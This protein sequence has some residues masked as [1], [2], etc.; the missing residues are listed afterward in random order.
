VVVTAATKRN[1]PPRLRV[2]LASEA[3]IGV[4]FRRGPSKLVRV[5]A[6]DRKRDKFRAC[7]RFNGRIL[8]GADMS[9]DGRYMMYSA[10]GGAAWAIPA[11]GGTWTAISRVPSLTAVALWGQSG[12][13]RG[14]RGMF[15][16]NHSY[17]LD[18]DANTFLIRDTN[19]LRREQK[20]RGCSREERDGWITTGPNVMNPAFEKTIPKGWTLRRKRRYP[21]H[22]LYEIE[23]PED[24]L[25]LQVPTWEWAD[26]DRDRLVWVEGGC[27]RAAKL[28]VRKLGTVRTLYDFNEPICKDS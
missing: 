4:V 14:C 17:C 16:S 25:T 24:G 21:K 1:A 27:L 19:M 18:S 3:P 23:Q 8:T 12:S 2:L 15:T 28:G 7:Q 22:D 5:Y 11:T 13:T 20:K 26:W 9:P 6:W 10:M